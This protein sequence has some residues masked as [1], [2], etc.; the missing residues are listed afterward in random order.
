MEHVFVSWSGGKDCC[1]ACYK[2]IANCQK[3]DY[4]AS[5]ITG[6]TGRLWPHYLSPEVLSMQAE[7]MQIPMLQWRTTLPDYD[8]EYKNMLLTLKQNG[9]TGGVFGDVSN[10][11]GL[12]VGHRQWIDGVCQSAGITPYLPLWNQGRETLMSEFIAAGFEAIIIAADNKQ[13]GKKWLGRKLDKDLLSELKRR[14]ELS[15]T[16]EVGYYHTLVL[17]GPLFT[18]RLEILKANKVMDKVIRKKI[19]GVPSDYTWYE[20]IWYLDILKC[21]LKPKV[22]DK[23]SDAHV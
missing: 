8:A 14:Y 16:G 20:D 15:P 21:G 12:H 10:G 4:L 5:V 19:Y 17:D 7:A 13:L 23:R 22:K 2:A 9:I 3:V 11:N 1:F 18:K 6:D